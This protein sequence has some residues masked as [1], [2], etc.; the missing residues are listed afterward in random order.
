M[1]PGILLS[2]WLI[3]FVLIF[4]GCGSND[5]AA[6]ASDTRDAG[7]IHISAD[8]SFKPVIDSQIGVFESSYPNANI[9]VHYKPEAEALKDFLVDSIR[10]VITTRGFSDREENLIADSLKVDPSKMT[11]AF[12]AIAVIVHPNATDSLFTMSELKDIL[13]GKSTRNKVPVFDGLQAT[14]TVRF[15]LDSVLRGDTLGDHVVAAESSQGVIDYVAKNPNAMGFIGVSWVGNNQDSLQL[16]FLERVK[17]AHI[18][19]VDN[20]GGYILPVQANIYAQ[21]YPM[22]RDLVY[23]LK[24]RHNGLAHGFASFL[25]GERGQLIFRRAYLVPAQLR[26]NVRPTSL[27]E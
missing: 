5:T 23:V 9:I 25:S 17:M 19:S 20:P 22:I 15:V 12:D 8:E 26:L 16:S 13:S 24:E 3:G 7:T 14:S 2:G 27:R 18:E 11:V 10:M 6:T 21:R 1:K 4:Y